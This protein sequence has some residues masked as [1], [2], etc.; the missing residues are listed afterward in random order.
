MLTPNDMWIAVGDQQNEWIS[1]QNDPDRVCKTHTE[2]AG[3]VPPWGTVSNPQGFYRG[4]RCC[5]Y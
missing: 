3:V 1:V 4:A 2:V 5:N